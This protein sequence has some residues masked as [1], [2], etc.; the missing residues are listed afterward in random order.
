MLSQ[1]WGC[2]W[3]S[4]DNYIWVINTFSVYKCASYIRGF[5]VIALSHW[6]Q[7]KMADLF[8][9]CFFLNTFYGTKMFNFLFKFYWNI[10]P[11]VHLTISQHCFRW[12]LGAEDMTNHYLNQWWLRILAHKCVTQPR[13]VYC[14]QC[15]KK[16]KTWYVIKIKLVL[17]LYLLEFHVNCRCRPLHW[18][19]DVSGGLAWASCQIR[20]IV[21]CACAGNAGIVFPATAFKGNC[22]LAIPACITARASRTCRDACRDR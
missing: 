1:G 7:D 15:E 12:W 2:S 9:R 21:D 8:S 20:K 4:A 13:W 14:H 6:G 3:S 10:L 17:S 11:R 19:Q 16:H 18:G 5:M 22:Q